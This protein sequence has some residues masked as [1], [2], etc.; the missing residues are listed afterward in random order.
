ML[1]DLEWDRASVAAEVSEPIV[2]IAVTEGQ[3]VHAGDLILQLDPRRIEA[4]LAW[5]QARADQAQAELDELRH[6]PRSE[7]I[8][9]AQGEAAR[10]AAATVEARRE[11]VRE[12]KLLHEGVTSRSAYEHALADEQGSE[13]GERSARAR[14]DELL[15]GSRREDV[16]QAAAALAAAQAQAQGLQLK[17]ER[18]TVRAPRDGRVDALPFKLGDQ[19]PA[20]AT[21][22]VVLAGSAPY[23]RIYV[24]ASRRAQLTIG[25]QCSVHV[26]G[27]ARLY[28]ATLRSLRSEP[29]FTPYYALNGDDASRLAYRAELLLSGDAAAQL[30][31]G[32]P[33][34][35]DCAAATGV[36]AR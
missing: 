14:L 7:S 9:A 13:A 25:A 6:G 21:L 30:P 31:A 1:G 10:A 34:A 16:D 24:P 23:A 19:P 17:R 32:L 8:H 29:A 2:R 18:L 28:P 33:V 11:R 27:I 4:D 22:A 26:E 20:G 15:H 36:A 5:A 35:A 3:V 12:E